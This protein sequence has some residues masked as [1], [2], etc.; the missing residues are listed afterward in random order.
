MPLCIRRVFPE[1]SCYA[2]QAFHPHPFPSPLKGEGFPCFSICSRAVF[3]KTFDNTI[4]FQR[5]LSQSSQVVNDFLKQ[6]PLTSAHPPICVTPNRL[7]SARRATH[8]LHLK[9]SRCQAT[10]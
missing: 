10:K 2:L 5:N 7:R 6:K 1:S 8:P 3:H 9:V 4:D